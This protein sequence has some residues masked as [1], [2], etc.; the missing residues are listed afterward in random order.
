MWKE[1]LLAA[2]G[3]QFTDSLAEDDDIFG[4]SVS[5]REK[6]DLVQVWNI[7]SQAVTEGR[8]LEKIHRLLPGVRFLA[9]FY[10][11]ELSHPLTII[12]LRS[13]WCSYSILWDLVKPLPG[14]WTNQP[15]IFRGSLGHM[16]DCIFL[17]SA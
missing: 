15:P 1:L 5:P 9:E 17:K 16:P 2:I 3:E 14:G 11:R 13:G 6:D 4:I 10:K 12:K 7:R 8:V